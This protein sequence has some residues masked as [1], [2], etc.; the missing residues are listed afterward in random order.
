MSTASIEHII[1]SINTAKDN[2]ENTTHPEMADQMTDLKSHTSAAGLEVAAIKLN[3]QT[4]SKR[5]ADLEAQMKDTV[6]KSELDNVNKRLTDVEA[7]LDRT[8]VALALHMKP[9]LAVGKAELRRAMIRK[10]QG[11]IQQT[12][13]TTV[14]R[15]LNV[16][17]NADDKWAATLTRKDF[18]DVGLEWM[19]DKY[20][21]FIQDSELTAKRNESVHRMATQNFL[22][23]LW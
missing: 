3:E 14:R 22:R 17:A 18:E 5:I 10:L 23:P 9:S 21:N 11:K 19:W 20:Q 7:D 8:K 2:A 15:A 6:S 1:H 4:S 12:K 16:E 13:K